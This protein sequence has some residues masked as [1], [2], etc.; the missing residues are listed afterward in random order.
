VGHRD[1]AS[2]APSVDLKAA[3]GVRIAATYETGDARQK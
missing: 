3:A 1:L 2:D